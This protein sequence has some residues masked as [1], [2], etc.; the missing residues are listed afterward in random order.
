MRKLPTEFDFPVSTKVSLAADTVRTE[1]I[2]LASRVSTTLF[3]LRSERGYRRLFSVMG[4]TSDTFARWKED[5]EFGCQRMTGVNPMHLER[6][7]AERLTNPDLRAAAVYVLNHR[8]SAERAAWHIDDA[9]RSGRP[10]S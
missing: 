2:A 9:I 3:P 5:T 4:G 1:A 8:Y 10:L 7:T 6:A